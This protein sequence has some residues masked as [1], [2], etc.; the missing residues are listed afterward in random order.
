MTMKVQ[1]IVVAPVDHFWISIAYYK[2]FCSWEMHVYSLSP[3]ILL[4][5]SALIWNILV[6]N[7]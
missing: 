3:G 2:P 4:L 5:F 1:L 6:D 7:N